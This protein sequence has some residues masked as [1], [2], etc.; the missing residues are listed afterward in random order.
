MEGNLK[1]GAYH[2]AAPYVEA[3]RQKS[4]RGYYNWIKRWGEGPSRILN[5]GYSISGRGRA[6]PTG[7]RSRGGARA[8]HWESSTRRL[9]PLIAQE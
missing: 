3:M 2:M 9:S 4:N 7:K 6:F 5:M 1:C 8:E